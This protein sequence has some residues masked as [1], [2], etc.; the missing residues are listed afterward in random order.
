MPHD[1]DPDS[2]AE[3]EALQDAIIEDEKQAGLGTIG[4]EVDMAR[5]E[6]HRCTLIPAETV[7]QRDRLARSGRPVVALRRDENGRTPLLVAPELLGP[8]TM[9]KV[10]RALADA[11]TE[12]DDRFQ[13]WGWRDPD[14]PPRY[15]ADQEAAITPDKDALAAIKHALGGGREG[16]HG[17]ATDDPGIH[18]L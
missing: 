5:F 3:V 8:R 15:I 16:R 4:K 7:D 6:L 14:T 17:I 18:T 1:L 2:L 13:Q 11:A 12:A 9:R 10:V